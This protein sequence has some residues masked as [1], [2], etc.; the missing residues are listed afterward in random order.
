MVRRVYRSRWTAYEQLATLGRAWEQIRIDGDADGATKE[1]A[2][3][4]DSDC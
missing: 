2:G 4:C 3:I 1:Q